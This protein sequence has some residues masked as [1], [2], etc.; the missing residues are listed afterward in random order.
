[1]NSVVG[2]QPTPQVMVRSLLLLHRR[3]LLHM[4]LVATLVS[5]DRRGCFS[6]RNTSSQYLLFILFGR[7]YKK[8]GTAILFFITSFSTAFG[9]RFLSLVAAALLLAA[10]SAAVPASQPHAHAHAVCSAGGCGC[11]LIGQTKRVCCLSF[12]TSLSHWL[13]HLQSTQPILCAIH[14]SMPLARHR[15]SVTARQHAGTPP[16]VLWDQNVTQ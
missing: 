16:S 9:G 15:C 6:V 14:A 7:I 5:V 13:L 10:R 8:K 11:T 3:L 4:L 1:M 12:F 2:A